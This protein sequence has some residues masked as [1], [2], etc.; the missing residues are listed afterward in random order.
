MRA[1]LGAGQTPLALAFLDT[2]ATHIALRRSDGGDDGIAFGVDC[3][4][5]HLRSDRSDYGD[6]ARLV[7][8]RRAIGLLLAHLARAARGALKARRGAI[9]LG[10]RRLGCDL[11]FFQLT[12][13]AR[14]TG[15]TRHRLGRIGNSCAGVDSSG[16]FGRR[17]ISN[18]DDRLGARLPDRRDGFG[19]RNWRSGLDWRSIHRV[20]NYLDAPFRLGRN[21]IARSR[22]GGKRNSIGF[23][24]CLGAA[25]W[26]GR[27]DGDA[28]RMNIGHGFLIFRIVHCSF[29]G[30]SDLAQRQPFILAQR[31]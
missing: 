8:A 19:W 14:G 17:R 28:V 22:C 5:N 11:D 6:I 18:N 16:D 31:S 23:D 27:H 13:R 10:R 29:L 2:G 1:G 9:N 15:S 3:I 20:G 7:D 30:W 26:L 4:G 24:L 21:D 12:R 25:F